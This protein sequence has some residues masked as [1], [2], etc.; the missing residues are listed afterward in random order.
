MGLVTR[1]AAPL[2]DMLAVGFLF[3]FSAKFKSGILQDT[4]TGTLVF[5]LVGRQ[6]E[7]FSN[8]LIYFSWNIKMEINFSK[9][10]IF[11]VL[12]VFVK[13]QLE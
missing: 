8:L 7:E 1:G 12:D 6:K 2:L 9:R 10:H 11:C 5:G 4:G 13:Y 3:P